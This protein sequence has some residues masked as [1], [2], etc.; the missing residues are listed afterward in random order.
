M[1]AISRFLRAVLVCALL[2]LTG[3][4]AAA[5]VFQGQT[6]GDNNTADP[7]ITLPSPAGNLLVPNRVLIAQLTFQKENVVVTAP[8]GWL[9]LSR[10][11]IVVQGQDLSQ[12]VFWKR[13]PNGETAGTYTFNFSKATKAAGTLLLYSGVD[14]VTPLLAAS[15]QT[16]NGNT[17]TAPGIADPTAGSML[18]A[19]YGIKSLTTITVPPA[20]MTQRATRQ[21]NL[22][23][24][25]WAYDELIAVDAA[26]TLPRVAIAA[27]SAVW[28]AQM[29]MLDDGTG[30]ANP[31][32][33]D[34]RL[35]VPA[36]AVVGT[37]AP[38]RVFI[39][40]VNGDPVAG[41]AVALTA[42]AGSTLGQATGTTDAAGLFETTITS[43]TIGFYDV[44]ASYDS[45]N[46]PGTPNQ[47]ILNGSP[48]TIEFFSAGPVDVNNAG[49]KLE[50]TDAAGVAGSASDTGAARVTLVDVDG[51]PIRN[52][53]VEFEVDGDAGLTT[54]TG[55]TNNA[56]QFS[57]TITDDTAEIVSVR[58]KFDA[59]ND[60]PPTTYVINGD[61]GDVTFVA[62][63]VDVSN[64]GTL[65]EV[66]DGAATANGTDAGEVRV[67]LLDA[68]DNPVSGRTVTFATTGNAQFVGSASGTTDASGQL[69]VD[70][71]DTTAQSVDVTVQFDS[72]GDA[73]ADTPVTNGSPGVVVFSAGPVDANAATT[74][75]EATDAAATA[76][77]VDTGAVRVTVTDA[78][79]N[80]IAGVAVELATANATAAF[81][82][83]TGTT[84]ASG[85]YSTTLTNT[86]AGTAAVTA[87]ID[88]DGNASTE[89]AIV[90]GSPA[91][92]VFSAGAVDPSN[93]NTK[94]EVLDG[95]AA[96]N[97]SDTATAR[98]TLADANGNPVPN[99]TVA[100]ATTGSAILT[101]GGTTDSN[102]QI[103]ASLTDAVAESVNVTATFD[104]NGD[105]AADAAVTN[106]SPAVLTFESLVD[107]TR[108]NTKLEATDAAAIANGTDAGTVVAT[109]VNSADQ[110]VAN[111]KVTFSTSGAA[112]LGSATGFTDVNGQF[113]TTVTNTVAGTTPVT[114]EFDANNDGTVDTAVVNGS[115]ANVVF[116]A[117]PV[118]VNN[119]GTLV[120]ATDAIALA[121]G[122]DTGTARV[123]LKDANGNAVAGIAVTFSLDAAGS[124]ATATGVT[125]ANGQFSSNV[126]S[127]VIG[128]TGVTVQ[129]D[130]NGDATADT[131]VINGSPAN[132]VFGEFDTDVSIQKKVSRGLTL[133]NGSGDVIEYTIVVA[134]VGATPVFGANVL[135]A[136]SAS[137]GTVTWT[138]AGSNGGVC[139]AASGNGDIDQDVDLPVGGSVTYVVTGFASVVTQAGIRNNAAVDLATDI[140]PSNNVSGDVYYR[141]SS[142][143]QVGGNTTPLA[144][145]CV[146][147]DS[148]ENP[149][150]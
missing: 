43:N 27:N 91:N 15:S 8:S 44:S 24:T 68:N 74:L 17:M 103:T 29:L 63:P 110:P 108:P 69:S 77:G 3:P 51:N 128:T 116:S 16:G 21:N 123:T 56:G 85:Q 39:S 137:L 142:S 84:D 47:A 1:N 72:N 37:N 119:V 65:I 20:G 48:T 130:S 23:V 80:P 102:G 95:T 64:A 71:T 7:M 141:C 18:V 135:D 78:N 30:E 143:V 19:V 117:G 93:A 100:F 101:G 52:F 131:A 58:A 45:D 41:V 70:L 125:N 98:V 89:T 10:E 139:G 42:E 40:D 109:L 138:C 4:V 145:E 129:F 99:V 36:E 122:V 144:Y 107:A 147:K 86:V 60:G 121:D 59:E 118:D 113:S 114:A 127:T 104:S 31:F 25:T 54:A 146:F 115:P 32:D 97:G 12:V 150:N 67:T 133:A 34:T 57:T 66:I 46:N 14:T 79:G 61:G 35:E 55:T 111:V 148:Y 49:T 38:V 11:D 134:N 96:A 62:G 132:I 140:D 6:T 149:T 92:V 88:A 33:A 105:L 26:S 83:A 106:G 90:N 81:F 126:T 2:L 124:L 112:V 82:D 87:N 120:E 9:L 28:I 94:I 53:A 13:V 73:T 75:I 136:M 5:I 22:P 50:I 76:D